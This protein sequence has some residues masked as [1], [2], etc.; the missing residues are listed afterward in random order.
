[1]M[2]IVKGVRQ[3][4]AR[5]QTKML[6]EGTMNIEDKCVFKSDDNEVSPL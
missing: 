4:R 3:I 2:I 5:E 6:K 1:M